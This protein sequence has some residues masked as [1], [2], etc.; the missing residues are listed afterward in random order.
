MAEYPEKLVLSSGAVTAEILPQWG[1]KMI[2][3]R[4]QDGYE[5]LYPAPYGPHTPD[6]S[7][8]APEDA[9][10]FDEMFPGVYP[11]NY[12]APPWQEEW[13]ADHGNLWYRTW[14]HAG[15][16]AEASLWVEDERIG[17]HFAR[18]LR[19]TDPL[20]LETEYQ[21]EN[22]SRHPLYWLYAAHILCPYHPGVELEIP[23]ADYRRIETFG[24][25]LPEV[26]QADAP[27]LLRQTAF[28]DDSAALYVSREVGPGRCV[29]RDLR[30]GKAM[31]VR[32]SAPVSYLGIWYNKAGWPEEKPISH[33]GLEPGIAGH[34]DLA[35]WLKMESPAPLEP[36]DQATWRLTMSVLR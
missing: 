12:P 11:Q 7:V 23:A 10:G 36:G 21:V 32:W 33:I 5:F 13:I 31:V 16:G 19:F 35:E 25:P 17:W 1:S 20:T 24:Q 28:P 6:P 3:F 18:H 27:H 29:Y 14:S 2:S 34:P 8:Y 30:A 22:R 15:G 9:Y 26:C 4:T